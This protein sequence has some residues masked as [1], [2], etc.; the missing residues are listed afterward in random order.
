MDELRFSAN[1]KTKMTVPVWL[2]VVMDAVLVNV[3]F[4]LTFLVR[5]GFK[6]PEYNLIA[7]YALVPWISVSSVAVFVSMGLYTVKRY[8][9]RNVLRLLAVGV[10]LQGVATM[11]GAFWVRQFAFPRSVLLLAPVFQL[12][13]L[14]VW[15]GL[16]LQLD[17]RFHGVKKLLIVGYDEDAERML[18][19]ILALPTGW[20]SVVAV[21]SPE[22]VTET[23]LDGV[24]AVLLTEKVHSDDKREIMA[25]CFEDGREAFVIPGLYE[26]LVK[27]A[28]YAQLQD[29]PVLEVPEILISPVKL[30]FKRVVDITVSLQALIITFPLF[31]V[32]A[33]LIKLTSPGPVFYLQKRVGYQGRE[34]N[35]YKFRSM[36]DNAEEKSGPML[37]VADDS[38]ITA[39]GRIIRVARMDE[40]PQLL[41]ILRG[42]MSLVGPRP[43]RRTF[44][45]E[46]L[47]EIPEYRYRY[48][49][50]PGLTGLAQVRSR[51]STTAKD[52]LS[53]DLN[54][55]INYSLLLDFKIMLETIPTVFSRESAVG[56]EAKGKK[57]VRS[58][59]F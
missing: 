6:I 38:R 32:I 48:L 22:K 39:V 20:F 23:V 46:F 34:F 45:E 43:E 15:R 5:Y 13:L 52:K 4:Y 37:A 16:V 42:D 36:V 59:G 53:Y 19:K 30:F 21:V 24:E 11:A 2:L 12:I 35:V 18:P 44:V 33:A 55:I 47:R 9:L 17:K 51:Y 8:T 50:K 26:M 57:A 41:N 49:V 54:Y 1:G 56:C 7:F 3:G 10:I 27:K 40:L 31:V 25:R 29:T 14:A 28:R 58:G